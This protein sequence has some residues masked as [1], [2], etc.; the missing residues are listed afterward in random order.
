[1]PH[2][3]FGCHTLPVCCNTL[4]MLVTL[5]VEIFRNKILGTLLMVSLHCA[6]LVAT[7][8]LEAVRWQF[9]HSPHLSTCYASRHYAENWQGYLGGRDCSLGPYM[10]CQA[11]CIKWQ[12]PN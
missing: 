7:A 12:L 10:G 1:M 8:N 2:C 3:P 5:P 11:L 9:G 6:H 4:P